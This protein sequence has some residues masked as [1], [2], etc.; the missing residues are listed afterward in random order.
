[1][2]PFAV[3]ASYEKHVIYVLCEDGMNYVSV[4]A[5]SVL[6]SDMMELRL[7]NIACCSGESMEKRASGVWAANGEENAES[8]GCPVSGVRLLRVCIS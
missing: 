5:V 8:C 2:N 4:V 7:S 1:M 6:V 3:Y